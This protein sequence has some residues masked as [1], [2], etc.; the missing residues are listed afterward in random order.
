MHIKKYLKNPKKILLLLLYKLSK[1][2]KNDEFYLKIFYR[3][4][5]GKKL[6]LQKPITYNEKLQWLKLNYKNPNYIE[7]VDKIKAKKYAGCTIG[8]EHIIPLLGIWNEFDDIDFSKLPNKFVLKT[9]H[10]C[11]GVVICKNKK[12]FNISKAKKIINKSLKHNYFFRGREFYY[13]K[14][15]PRILAEEFMVDESGYELKDYKF[16]CFD[17]IPKAMFIATGRP[18]DTRFD[19][20]DIEFNHLAFINGYKNADI[21]PKKPKN[22]EKMVELSAKLSEN[23]PHVRVDFYNVNGRI[24]FGEMTFSHWGGMKAFEPEEWDHKFGEWIKLPEK[25]E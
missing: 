20:F 12:K 24:Y 23:I 2:F 15:K 11:G 16:F 22:F 8:K 3:I 7:M 10:G 18:Y 5:I 25:H 21:Q 1:F 6:T 19:F 9:S 13:K 4:S 14:I 17:G